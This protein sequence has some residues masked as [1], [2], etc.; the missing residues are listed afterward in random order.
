[1]YKL[2]FTIDINRRFLLLL[3]GDVEENPGPADKNTCPCEEEQ[4]DRYVLFIK[5]AKCSQKWHIKCVGLDNITDK[6]LQKLTK[7]NC[8]LCYVLP[9]AVRRNQE[10]E[11]QLDETDILTTMKREMANMETRLLEKITQHRD[12]SYADIATNVKDLRQDQRHG[13]K[14]MENMMKQN[15]TREDPDKIEKE[16]KTCIVLKPRDPKIRQSRD[17]KAAFSKR[18]PLIHLQKAINTVG[19]SILLEFDDKDTASKIIEDW[20][21]TLFGG[22]E[23]IKGY[24]IKHTAGL[25]KQVENLSEQEIQDSIKQDYPDAF[26]ELFQR[27]NR[28]TGTVKI[29]FKNEES[30]NQALQQKIKISSQIYTVEIFKPKPRIIKCN[31]CQNFGHV[32]RLC[33]NNPVCGKCC[34]TTHETKD[35]E[36]QPENYKCAHCGGNHITGSYTCEKVKDKMDQL[37]KRENGPQ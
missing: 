15:K 36:I 13:N 28:F 11:N 35:C 30:L 24:K 25:I 12:S 3:A 2:F 19:G 7:W 14:L 27:N 26:I 8:P 20:D 23:G 33:N 22:N 4:T 9:P 21:K 5:C 17:I 32:S 6:A 16:A 1:M 18:Y 34:S 10:E 29:S 31:K 37:S